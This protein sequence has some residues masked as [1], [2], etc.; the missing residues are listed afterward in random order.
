MAVTPLIKPI[1]TKKG[2]FY[3]FQS[4]L[5]DLNLTFNNNGANKF[6]F[7]KFVL[8]RIPEIGDPNTQET[9]GQ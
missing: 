8:L 3:T 1:Q 4:A 5:E 9:I 6:K 2:I 7:S